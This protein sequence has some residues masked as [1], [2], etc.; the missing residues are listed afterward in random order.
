MRAC[1]LVDVG[2]FEVRDVPDPFLEPHMVLVAPRAIGVCGTDFHIHA[3][4]FNFNLDELGRPIPLTA[5]PQILG[6]EIAGVVEE[7]GAEVADLRPN[8]WGEVLRPALAD[9]KGWAA[10][11]TIA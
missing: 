5:T 1:V 8:V 3:G 10:C 2:R 11:V 7:V 6:H 4:E 9:R